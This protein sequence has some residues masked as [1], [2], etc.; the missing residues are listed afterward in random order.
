MEFKREYPRAGLVGTGTLTVVDGKQGKRELAFDV[1]NISATGLLVSNAVSLEKGDWVKVK[2][3]LSGRFDRTILLEGEIVST[4]AQGD[5]WEHAIKITKIE[6]KNRIEIDEMVEASTIST[7]HSSGALAYEED[8]DSD[9]AANWP[10]E[11]PSPRE[12]P[13]GTPKS[14]QKRA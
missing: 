9:L 12:M 7:L 2:V 8:E 6:T 3:E 10:E 13:V 1:V 4:S 14:A 11:T 5:R